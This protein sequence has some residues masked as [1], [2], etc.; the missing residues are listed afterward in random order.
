MLAKVYSCAVVGLDGVLVEVE[1]DAGSPHGQPGIVIVGLPDTAVQES[2]ERVRAAIR[3]SGGRIPFGKVTINLAPADIKKAGPTYDL[4]IAIGILLASGQLEADLSDALIVGELSLDGVLRHTPGIIAMVSHA[5]QKEMRRAFVPYDDAKEAA[6]IGGIE[7]YPV[8]TL[9]D[10]VN[11][12]TGDAPIEPYRADADEVAGER[13]ARIDF[14]EIRGQEHVKRGLEVAAAGAHNVLMSGPPGSG[15]TMLARALPTIL[16]PMSIQEALEVTKIY[17]VRGLLPPDTPLI[18]DRPFRAPHHGT[19]SVGLIGGG[20]WPRPGEVSLAH[21]GVLF[22]D[23]L[24][25]FPAA[26]LEMLRQPLEDRQ[27]TIGRATGTVTFPANFALVAAMNPCPCGY[28][29]DPARECRCA[30]AAIARYQK[31]ISGPLLDRIDIH[32]EV[33]RI[34]YEQLADRRPGE[35]SAAVRARVEAARAIQAE[36]FAGT[37]LVTNAD[38]G[39]RELAEYV[40]LDAVGEEM[41]KA[42]V[43][44]LQLSARAYHRVLKLAR[45]IADLAGVEQVRPEHIAEALQYRPRQLGVG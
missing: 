8:R 22:L 24:P 42:A 3:N 13:T 6:L 4:P 15:K 9:A 26:T 2:R 5:A 12:L 29:G 45:T 39:P 18:R 28:F 16:P 1:V 21:R 23:E 25:E 10:L 43:R 27:V 7:I 41:M 40:V 11:H 36:R 33:P 17:S 34:A 35:S 30:P 32:V 37:G 44:Q 31:K 38:M 19:S 14:A 20:S